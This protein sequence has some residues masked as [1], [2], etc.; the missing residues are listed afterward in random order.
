MAVLAVFKTLSLFFETGM[1]QYVQRVGHTNGWN[2]LYD[3]SD[4]VKGAWAVLWC[5]CTGLCEPRP[6]AIL[7]HSLVACVLSFV[8]RVCVSVFVCAV[9]CRHDDVCGDCAAGHGLVQS[10]AVP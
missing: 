7:S 8:R 3:I 5:D 10:E 9:S 6:A 4:F 2:V 1:I